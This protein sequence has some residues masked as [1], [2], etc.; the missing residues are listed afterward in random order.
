LRRHV[1]NDGESGDYV[2][3]LVAHR[4]VMGL[5]KP[6]AAGGGERKGHAVRHDTLAGEDSLELFVRSNLL[7][8]RKQFESAVA[9]N[10]L[11]VDAGDA[12]HRR[13]PD[14]EPVL[15]IKNYDSIQTA[16]DTLR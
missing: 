5:R 1:A 15:L 11:P 8:K 12:L 4:R 13:I 16:L 7:Q 6:A 9:E 10:F 2:A 3:A 14:H